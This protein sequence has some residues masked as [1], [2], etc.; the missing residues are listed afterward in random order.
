MILELDN[1]LIQI[2][3]LNI[4]CAGT[5]PVASQQQWKMDFSNDSALRLVPVTTSA[6]KKLSS[7]VENKA[8]LVAWLP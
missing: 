1:S 6:R 3:C 5:E 4:H 7:A 2:V 8:F